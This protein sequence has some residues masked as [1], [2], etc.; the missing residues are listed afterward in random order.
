MSND[1][2]RI[3]IATL[4]DAPAYKRYLDG[5]RKE[6]LST[7]IPPRHSAPRPVSKYEEFILQHDGNGGSVL[8]L[9]EENSVLIGTI[10]LT[11]I[12][13]Q[14]LD[15]AVFLGLN[16]KKAFR[17]KGIGTA[18]LLHGMDWAKKSQLLK[19]LNWKC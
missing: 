14:E 16:V 9:A 3:R 19:E 15:H 11:K 10:H 13:R 6:R 5:I 7:L 4:Q 1:K 12:E 18:L 2:V 8:F 17:G